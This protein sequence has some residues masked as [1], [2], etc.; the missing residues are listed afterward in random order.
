MF[1]YIKSFLMNNK[2]E[3]GVSIRASKATMGIGNILS[4]GH[5]SFRG[6]RM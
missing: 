4:E 5:S 3:L 1:K 6:I 2:E